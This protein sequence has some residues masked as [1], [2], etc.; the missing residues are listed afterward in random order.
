M[1]IR[2]IV[3]Y[4]DERLTE[5]SKEIELIDKSV[6]TLIDDMVD[7]LYDAPGVG[8][9]APQV[10]KNVRITVI[11]TSVGEDPDALLK[12]INPEMISKE[13]SQKEEEGCLSLPGITEEVERPLKCRVKALTPEE[14][15][16]ELE[17]EGLLARVLDHEID[18]LNGILFIRHLSSLK[19]KLIK[20]EIKKQIETGDWRKANV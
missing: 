6:K 17:A 19:R 11:D 3:T 5:P 14:E 16:I 2:E 10:G 8:L 1:A 20:K 12:L 15:K 18:H 7:T 9:A 13:G 4:P